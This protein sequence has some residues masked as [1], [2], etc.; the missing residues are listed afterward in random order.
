MEEVQN[1]VLHPALFCSQFID[2]VA[3]DVRLWSPQLV[4]CFFESLH[5][6]HA[7]G[8]RLFIPSTK[9][10]QPVQNGYRSLRL[11]KKDHFRLRHRGHSKYSNFAIA[12]KA[13]VSQDF[14]RT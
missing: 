13:A 10:G 5:P 2:P 11:S 1:A 6:N 14:A 4:A 8:K 12:G 9:D 3:E 7:L